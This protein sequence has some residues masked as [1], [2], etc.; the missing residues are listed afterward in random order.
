MNRLTPNIPMAAMCA[1][2][3][4]AA[5]LSVSAAAETPLF[6]MASVST[7]DPM[8]PI[9]FPLISRDGK[10][11]AVVRHASG[12]KVGLVVDLISVPSRRVTRSV[13]LL[14]AF[15]SKRPLSDDVQRNLAQRLD[16]LNASI[17][18][19]D[20]RPM[21]LLYKSQWQRDLAFNETFENGSYRIVLQHPSGS[22][23]ITSS[24][25]KGEALDLPQPPLP[26]NPVTDC[27]QQTIPVE[28]WFDIKENILVIRR[29]NVPLET[30]NSADEWSIQS[31][32]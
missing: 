31:L 5:L 15:E 2:L 30:C 14:S 6:D 10:H 4:V 16:E 26:I 29:M 27:L 23:R 7:T 21:P 28:G 1:A 13:E 12:R 25:A 3:A 11:V 24:L 17:A 18:P 19:Q 22:L 20:F 32:P 8:L 9:D